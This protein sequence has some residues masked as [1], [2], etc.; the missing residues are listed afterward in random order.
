MREH[1][2][3]PRNWRPHILVFAG[4][5]AKRLGLVRLASWLNQ[6][7]GILTACRLVPGGVPEH[8]DELDDLKRT[9]DRDLA[10]EKLVAF[11][12]VAA[13]PD[14]ETGVVS[15]AQANGIAGLRSNTVMFGCPGKPE[16]LQ[17][18]LRLVRRMS[19]LK[20]S[21]IIARLNWQLEPGRRKRIDIWWRG[22]QRNGDLMLLLAHLL[23]LN[24][25]WRDARIAVRCIVSN[26]SKREGAEKDLAVIVPESRIRVETEVIVKPADRSVVEVMHETSG[27]ASIVFLGLMDPEPG[28][29]ADH[30]RRLTEAVRGSNTTVLVRNASEFAGRLV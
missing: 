12:E 9:M 11:S 23:R 16:R 22:K 13:V 7:R 19:R 20:K 10:R 28:S 30:A 24:A 26:E 18:Q 8:T 2:A 6:D 14:F 15:V 3:D 17:A 4:D 21:T 29:E 1:E 5:T 25:E 27:D